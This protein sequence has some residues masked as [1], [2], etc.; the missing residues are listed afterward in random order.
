MAEGVQKLQGHLAAGALASL[1]SGQP[2]SALE[3][4]SLLPLPPEGG[5]VQLPAG[6]L[7]LPGVRLP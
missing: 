1:D 7:R 5:G 6:G 2:G 4:G 3:G